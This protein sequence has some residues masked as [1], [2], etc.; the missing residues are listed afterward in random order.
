MDCGSRKHADVDV[1]DLDQD[2]WICCTHVFAASGEGNAHTCCPS[3]CASWKGC[4]KDEKLAHRACFPSSSAHASHVN[5]VSVRRCRCSNLAVTICS[6][7]PG[8]GPRRVGGCGRRLWVAGLKI[9][10]SLAVKD[11]SSGRR[12]AG[13][14]SSAEVGGCCCGM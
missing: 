12:G 9:A 7:V 13:L 8:G 14:T 1:S 4:A 5:V 3:M 10:R 6:F 11:S 2:A